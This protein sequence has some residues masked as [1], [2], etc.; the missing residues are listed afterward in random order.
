MEQESMLLLG[1][2]LIIVQVIGL[3]MAV[4]ACSDD[5]TNS[6][7]CAGVGDCSDDVARIDPVAL[8]SIWSQPFCRLC[9]LAQAG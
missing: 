1:Y 3:L 9:A 6:A 7:R 4:G 8:S 5:I 2:V